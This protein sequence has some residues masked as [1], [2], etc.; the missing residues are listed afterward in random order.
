[1]AARQWHMAVYDF[2]FLAME[3]SPEQEEFLGQF[4][5]LGTLRDEFYACARTHLGGGQSH[6]ARR[7]RQ[8]ASSVRQLARFNAV[9]EGGDEPIA[10]EEVGV[11]DQ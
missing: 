8:L 5:V 6:P 4:R 2:S 1:M 7:G 9:R 3:E 10:P 11:A